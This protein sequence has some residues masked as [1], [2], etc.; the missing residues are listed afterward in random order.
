[1]LLLLDDGFSG[2]LVGTAAA[3]ELLLD[4]LDDGVV[5]AGESLGIDTVKVLMGDLILELGLDLGLDSLNDLACGDLLACGGLLA[6]FGFFMLGG[7]RGAGCV[8]LGGRR[9]AGSV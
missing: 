8:L 3:T 1:M 9:G 5:M 6:A 2:L 4:M 7:R